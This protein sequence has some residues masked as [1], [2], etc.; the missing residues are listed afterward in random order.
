MNRS[1]L[2]FILMV[3]IFGGLYAQ[4]KENKSKYWKIDGNLSLNFSQVSLS[5]WS[6]GGEG[7][8][9]GTFIFNI[10]AN[11]KKGKHAW[12][13]TLEFEY[14]RIK[15][16]SEGS[17][18]SIDKLNMASKYGYEIGNNWFFATLG[19]FKTQVDKGYNYPNK[20]VYISTFMAPAYLNVAV[21]FDYKPK[22]WI[23]IFL[24]PADLKSTFVMDNDLSDAGSF[25]VDPGDKYKAEIG[26]FVKVVANKKDLIKNV[27]FESTFD[28]FSNYTDNP[29]YIDVNWD[30]RF[31]MKINK[32]LSANVG[33][34]FRYDNDIKYIDDKSVVRGARVQVKQFL[35]IGISYKFN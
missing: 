1:I 14:G 6:E 29:H 15:N 21:G 32:Y 5:N 9:A 25:G 24:S 31:N 13:N 28:A 30:I 4:E 19:D 10:N 26:A 11:R 16:D 20:E 3:L 27:D 35:G 17:K 7:S 34:T 12:D 22:E 2:T 33:A 18:K 8:V 23:S